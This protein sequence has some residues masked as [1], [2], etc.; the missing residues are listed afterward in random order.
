MIESLKEESV[1]SEYN[2]SHFPDVYELSGKGCIESAEARGV[3]L[4]RELKHLVIQSDT[5]R[6]MI[7]IQAHKK[8]SFPLLKKITNCKNMELADL[9]ELNIRKGEVSP[10][11]SE[12]WDMPHIIDSSVLELE[13][14]TTNDGT[15]TGFIRFNPMV[16]LRAPS[17]VI[18]SI[19][20]KES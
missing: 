2:I 4:E 10:F 14:M 3:E 18:E 1:I 11:R 19:A 20:H 8:V 7:H 17:V 16:L 5:S 15:R 6:F 9:S 13:W 12:F